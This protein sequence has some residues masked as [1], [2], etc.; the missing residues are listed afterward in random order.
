ML[1]RIHPDCILCTGP[2]GT[3]KQ[4]DSIIIGVANAGGE[5]GIR[6]HSPLRHSLFLKIDETELFRLTFRR[7]MV[8]YPRNYPIAR[9]APAPLAGT[10]SGRTLKRRDCDRQ[11][12]HIS[13]RRGQPLNRG[14]AQRELNFLAF[15]AFRSNSAKF[16]RLNVTLRNAQT[17]QPTTI[18]RNHSMAMGE[19][20]PCP[21]AYADFQLMEQDDCVLA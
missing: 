18:A 4:E 7:S 5:R 10:S 12:G 9:S 15:R 16:R 1:D 3:G 11:R 6:C 2:Y 20:S 19:T 13:H 17:R 14:C 21:P 8:G